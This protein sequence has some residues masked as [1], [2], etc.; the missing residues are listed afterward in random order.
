MRDIPTRWGKPGHL[1][2]AKAHWCLV[3]IQSCMDIVDSFLVEAL[4]CNALL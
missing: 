3:D 4:C 1:F 2:C